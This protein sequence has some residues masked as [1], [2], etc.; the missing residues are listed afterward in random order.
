MSE[1]ETAMQCPK[2]KA[3]MEVRYYKSADQ[4]VTE[5][6]RWLPQEL[7][8]KPVFLCPKCLNV[9]EGY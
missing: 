5:V 9:I 3:E 6:L 4:A 8:G 2:C 7:I 1:K